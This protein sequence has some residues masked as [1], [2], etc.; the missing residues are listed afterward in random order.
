M[1]KPAGTA[2]KTAPEPAELPPPQ[3]QRRERIV[4]AA[5]ELLEAR[6]YEQIQI[7]D[8]SERA[9][10]AL[11]TLY[12]Y[13]TSKEHLYAAALLKWSKSYNLQT[14]T[15][16]ALGSDAAAHPLPAPADRPRG[17]PPAPAAAGRDGARQL[18]RPERAHLFEQ[19]AARH[20]EVL[21]AALHDVAPDRADA[22]VEAT[23]S[24]L[25]TQLRGWRAR[26]LHH[27]RRRALGGPRGRP[28]ASGRPG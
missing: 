21:T 18:T 5:I 27:H 26:P 7:R 28:G 6:E 17:G 4:Q 2:T 25:A 15:G 19:L 23:Y 13:F 12:R 16:Q 9:D 11:A 24:V 8:V 14:R 20:V 1:V 10:V 3:R 22:I